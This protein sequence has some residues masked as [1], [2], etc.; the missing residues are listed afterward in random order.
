MRNVDVVKAGVAGPLQL[1]NPGLQIQIPKHVVRDKT[2]WEQQHQNHDQLEAALLQQGVHVGFFGENHNNVSVTGRD[3]DQRDDETRDGPADAVRQVP[4][5]QV[6]GGG[7]K[8]R[9]RWVTWS[10]VKEHI[11]KDL[12][13]DQKPDQET[14]GHGVTAADFPHHPHR[15][16]DAQVPVDADAGEEADAAVQVEVEA[17]AR[18]LAEGPTEHP[19]A[20]LRVINDEKRQ[21]EEVE[22]IRDSQVQHEDVDVS[23]LVPVGADASQTQEVGQGPDNKHDDEHGR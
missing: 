2:D 8:T 4:L 13:D 23:D 7:V 22:Q 19:A 12:N 11:R 20:L 6:V 17:E 9:V 10:F 15:M 3:D 18:H 21:R 1:Q 16:D 5:D 14:Y